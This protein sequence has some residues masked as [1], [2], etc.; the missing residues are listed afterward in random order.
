MC[1]TMFARDEYQYSVGNLPLIHALISMDRERMTL[2]ELIRI[3]H[4]DKVKILD[5]EDLVNENIVSSLDDRI[6]I[7]EDAKKT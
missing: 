3:S 7:E 5:V 2:F 4:G 1:D 6:E